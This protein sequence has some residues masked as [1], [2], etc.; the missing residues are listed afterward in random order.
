MGGIGG[1]MNPIGGGFTGG[2]GGSKRAGELGG[3]GLGGNTEV[4]SDVLEELM[5]WI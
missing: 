2:C 1:G 4:G 5:P 3:T